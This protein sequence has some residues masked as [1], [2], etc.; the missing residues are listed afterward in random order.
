MGEERVSEPE[1]SNLAVSYSYGLRR[2]SM[3]RG[4]ADVAEGAKKGQNDGY[5]VLS[6]LDWKA[7]GPNRGQRSGI[8]R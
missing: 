1:K 7:L 2:A 8:S 3:S 4:I 6:E 5:E